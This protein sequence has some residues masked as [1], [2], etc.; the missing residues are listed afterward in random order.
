MVFVECVSWVE[1]IPGMGMLN[2]SLSQACSIR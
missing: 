1:G 2:P